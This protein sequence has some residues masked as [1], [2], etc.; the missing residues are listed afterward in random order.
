MRTFG[1]VQ[2]KRMALEKNSC[3]NNSER[4]GGRARRLGAGDP[5]SVTPTE[6]YGVVPQHD[7]VAPTLTLSSPMLKGMGGTY[8][9][10][11]DDN[12]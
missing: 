1:P 9:T 6:S 5:Y 3:Y 4:G 8:T 2:C 11:T 12:G 10:R 7:T